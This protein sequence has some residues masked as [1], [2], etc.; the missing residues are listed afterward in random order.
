M[1]VASHKRCRRPYPRLLDMLP[2]NASGPYGLLSCSSAPAE[3]WA[4]CTGVGSSCGVIEGGQMLFAQHGAAHLPGGL[5]P[6]VDDAGRVS[7]VN[8]PTEVRLHYTP[9]IV[10]EAGRCSA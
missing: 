4:A 3:V 8:V 6:S 5:A 1:V 10:T 9:L 7:V 2:V